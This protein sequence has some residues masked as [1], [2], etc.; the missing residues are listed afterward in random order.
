MHRFPSSAEGDCPA[1]T[2]RCQF[3]TL[4]GPWKAFAA[5]TRRRARSSGT[6][7]L[8]AHSD[9]VFRMEERFEQGGSLRLLLIGEFDVAVVDLV[10]SRLRELRALLWPQEG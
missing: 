1:L 5:G 7:V 9:R 4:R 2:L 6:T 3:G 10:S 8:M